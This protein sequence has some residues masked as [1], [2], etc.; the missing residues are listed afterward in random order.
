[1]ALQDFSRRVFP[2]GY[3]F[4]AACT[5][6]IR[7]ASIEADR[8]EIEGSDTTVL[9]EKLPNR[10][11]IL[12]KGLFLRELKIETTSLLDSMP[13]VHLLPF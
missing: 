6:S 2:E 7:D 10:Y 3:M 9:L 11:Y 13:L 12:L 4:R 8:I 5:R 1:L